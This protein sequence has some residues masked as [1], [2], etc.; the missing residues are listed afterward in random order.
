MVS[1]R[2]FSVGERVDGVDA[3]LQPSRPLEVELELFGGLLHFRR[4][5]VDE[6][7]VVS[8]EEALDAPHV[9]GVLLGRNG[10]ATGAGAQP[11]V[12]V[13]AGPGI[14]LQ[15]GERVLLQRA[16]ES[17]PVGAGGGAQGHHAPGDVDHLPGG[18][19]VGERTEVLRVG[20]VFL[21]GVLDGREHIAF[22]ERDEGVALVVLE[23]RIEK[24]AVLVDEV[25][26]QHERLV[27]VV[28]DEVVEGV[29]GLHEQGNLAL[30]VLEVRIEKRAVLVDEV[31]LQHERLV[32]VVDDEVVE[33]VDGLHEQ[34]NLCAI[35][36]EVH[37][38]AHARP[39]LLG[40]ADV[41]DLA[42]GVFP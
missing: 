24:R 15:D 21:A 8:G 18:A 33:G 39:Q 36:L 13:E 2:A 25:L 34:G 32:L 9:L 11:H 28:D 41:D 29:D 12:A 7:A 6:L 31:L 35:V 10:P 42:G 16:R 5:L 19:G 27:L 23:V 17:P 26:L 22:G 30:V 37:V 14:A 4:Q 38:L 40:L 20:L 1:M 3:R